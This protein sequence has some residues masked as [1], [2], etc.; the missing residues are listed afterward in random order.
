MHLT[1]GGL[2]NNA[3]CLVRPVQSQTTPLQR[4]LQRNTSLQNRL[5]QELGKP[6]ATIHP[7]TPLCSA[8]AVY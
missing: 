4:L 8:K 5:G 7:S 6:K 2:A 1:R 3:L